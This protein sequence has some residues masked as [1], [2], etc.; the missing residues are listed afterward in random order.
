MFVLLIVFSRSYLLPTSRLSNVETILNER[1]NFDLHS[2]ISFMKKMKTYNQTSE[3]ICRMTFKL[4]LLKASLFDEK[5]AESFSDRYDWLVVNSSCLLISKKSLKYNDASKK[6]AEFNISKLFYIQNEKDLAIYKKLRY[7]L[8][9]LNNK[10]TGNKNR[11]YN[12]FIGLSYF[13]SGN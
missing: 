11:T 10:K 13:D 8:Q 9:T 5:L 4:Q 1:E 2:V 3:N 12:Y 6:C 7:H